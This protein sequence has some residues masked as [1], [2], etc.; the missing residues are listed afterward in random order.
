MP[1]EI[2]HPDGRIEHPSVRRE[3]TDA[4]FGWIIGLLSG[5]AALAVV[6]FA[7]IFVY[8]RAYR[9]YQ[10]DIKKSSFPLAP[11][12]STA[13]PAKPRLEQID[14]QEQL[15]NPSVYKTEAANEDILNSYGTTQDKDY[16][17]IP[18]AEAMKL[19]DKKL[20]ARPTPPADQARRANG[21]VDAGESNSGRL[22]RSTPR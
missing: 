3:R 4:S 15:D 13:L 21:L 19:L 17:R 16:V 8:F 22:F 9:D 10:A 5:S 14:R 6:I 12:S 2:R 7:S 1:E 11:V 18:I 20:P